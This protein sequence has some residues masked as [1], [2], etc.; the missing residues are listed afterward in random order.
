M[1]VIVLGALLLLAARAKG[2][3][4]GSGPFAAPYLI[5][6]PCWDYHALR[7]IATDRL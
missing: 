4:A 3:S 6:A 5:L 1:V 7:P 2:Y